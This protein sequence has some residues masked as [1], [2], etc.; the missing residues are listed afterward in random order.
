MNQTKVVALR[1]GHPMVD[2]EI[3]LNDLS[4]NYSKVKVFFLMK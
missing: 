2:L 3:V 1:R 4:Q